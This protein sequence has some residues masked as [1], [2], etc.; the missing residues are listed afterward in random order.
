M[1]LENLKEKILNNNVDNSSFI[2]KYSDNKFICNQYVNEIAKVKNIPKI[3]IDNLNDIGDNTSLFGDVVE[4]LYIY[5]VEKLNIKVPIDIKNLIVICSSISEEQSLDVIDVTKVLPWHIEDY[6]KVNVPGLSDN[7]VKWLC[8]ICKNDIYRISSECKKLSIFPEKSQQ[9]IFNLINDT[10][11]YCD[12]NSLTIYNFTNAVMKKDI[13]TIKDVISDL[14]YIDIEGS[15][16]ITIFHNQFKKL[17]QI[18]LNPKA[19]AETLGISAK[20]FNAIKYNSKTFTQK[21]LI[22]IYNFITKLDLKLKSG[23]FQFSSDARTNNAKFV[24]YITMNLI[25]LMLIKD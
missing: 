11:G 5:D 12:L 7:Q 19:T 23:E 4:A 8:D 15:G 18:Q 2:L 16:L 13:S 17:I 3:F 14:K 24:E 6:V 9:S 22:S 20:Q 10:N 1:T 21:Q 25:N